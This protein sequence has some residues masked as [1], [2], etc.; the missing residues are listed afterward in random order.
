MGEF[1][2]DIFTVSYHIGSAAFGVFLVLRV[3]ERARCQGKVARIR[4]CGRRGQG[5]TL[6]G[7]SPCG[8]VLLG[9]KRHV[10][11]LTTARYASA[12]PAG[13][14]ELTLQ[15]VSYCKPRWGIRWFDD[16]VSNRRVVTLYVP[17]RDR[18]RRGLILGPR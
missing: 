14:G 6:G 12:R 4:A 9:E 16:F 10:N 2:K 1:I 18:A 11:I 7:V 15:S 5:L 3:A 8:R 17:P 13:A